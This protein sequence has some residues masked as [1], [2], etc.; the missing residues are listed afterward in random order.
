[1]NVCGLVVGCFVGG[2]WVD[3][4]QTDVTD[5]LQPSR[6]VERPFLDREQQVLMSLGE[7]FPPIKGLAASAMDQISY[8][9]DVPATAARC[10]HTARI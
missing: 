7:N 9:G 3:T 4:P 5:N 1:M 8:V 6:I 2:K 10:P